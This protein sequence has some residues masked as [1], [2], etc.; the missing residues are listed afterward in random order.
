MTKVQIELDEIEV[1]IVEI[2]KAIKG[3]K[4]KKQAIKD[5][6]KEHID[7]LDKFQ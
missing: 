7:I 4:S 3:T 1:K 2:Y 5:L 6:I